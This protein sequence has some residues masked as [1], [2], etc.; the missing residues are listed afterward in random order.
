MAGAADGLEMKFVIPSVSLVS[1]GVRAFHRICPM[2]QRQMRQMRQS[3]SA[4]SFIHFLPSPLLL[5]P[6][7][8]RRGSL[9]A[10]C[11]FVSII[12][13]DVETLAIRRLSALI[14]EAFIVSQCCAKTAATFLRRPDYPSICRRKC[15]RCF[16]PIRIFPRTDLSLSLSL[17]LSLFFSPLSAAAHRINPPL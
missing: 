4:F 13:R 17:S 2:K 6:P 16:S 7:T 9:G 1:L 15:H 11:R 14:N 10:R 3:I 5:P 12:N 8:K